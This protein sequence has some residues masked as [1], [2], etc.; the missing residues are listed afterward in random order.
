MGGTYRLAQQ[1]LAF[2]E[3]SAARSYRT[4]PATASFWQSVYEWRAGVTIYPTGRVSHN[5]TG[6]D[7]IPG[8]GYS[9]AT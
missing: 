3:Y 4:H 2:Q 6:D 8:V 1:L 9:A 7:D 5:S